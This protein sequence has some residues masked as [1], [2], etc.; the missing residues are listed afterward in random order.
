[1]IPKLKDLVSGKARG[2]IKTIN[3]EAEVALSF[4]KNMYKIDTLEAYQKGLSD[5]RK[6]LT[7]IAK[8][9]RELRK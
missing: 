1:M 9:S 3:H 8:L 7:L 2:S 4:I 6:K 5:V